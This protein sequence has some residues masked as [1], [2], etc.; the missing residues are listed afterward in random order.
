M[1]RATDGFFL[2]EYVLICVV[3]LPCAKSSLSDTKPRWDQRFFQGPGLNNFNLALS[4]RTAL[5]ARAGMDFRAEFF[6]IF[7]HTQFSSVD[8]NFLSST[9]G[10]AIHAQDPRIGQLGLKLTF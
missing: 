3:W 10:Q 6:N 2:Y 9:F 5:F 8:G 7:N 1:I 4:K